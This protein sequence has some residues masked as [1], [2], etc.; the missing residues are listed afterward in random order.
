[1][2]GVLSY[3]PSIIILQVSNCKAQGACMHAYMYMYVPMYLTYVCTYICSYNTYIHAATLVVLTSEISPR[4]LG[5]PIQL[6]HP[7]WDVHFGGVVG[8]SCN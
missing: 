5:A 7:L 6:G 1:M 4:L 3:V 8:F 2:Y